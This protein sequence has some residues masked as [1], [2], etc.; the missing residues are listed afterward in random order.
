MASTLT[1]IRLKP[2]LF[3]LEPGVAHLNHGSYGA[4]PLPVLEARRRAE[5]QLERSP[6][7]FYRQELFPAL[8]VVRNQVARFLDT[9]PAG[10]VL[11]RN[12]TEAVQ[13]VLGSLSFRPGDEIVYTD[14]AYSWVKTAITRT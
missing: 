7:R 4:V 14:H 2:E 3:L 10:L 13:V 9:D 11:V 5:E 6:E 1:H 8:D 12:V